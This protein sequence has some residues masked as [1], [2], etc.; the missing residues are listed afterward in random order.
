M[1]DRLYAGFVRN[2]EKPGL[3][4]RDDIHTAYALYLKSNRAV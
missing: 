3:L 1:P 4:E 2:S